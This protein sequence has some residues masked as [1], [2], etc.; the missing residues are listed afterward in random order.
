MVDL[1]GTDLARAA[2]RRQFVT[3]EKVDIRF[4]FT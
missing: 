1:A 2:A 3:P 4:R